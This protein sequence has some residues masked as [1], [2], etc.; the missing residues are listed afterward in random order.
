MINKYLDALA[1]YCDR[2][3]LTS[4][5]KDFY[6]RNSRRFLNFWGPEHHNYTIDDA[7]EYVDHLIFSGTMQA[8]SI[9]ASIR[10]IRILYEKVFHILWDH[11]YIP[12]LVEDKH[13]PNVITLEEFELLLNNVKSLKYKALYALMFSSGLRVSEAV[14]LR[15]DDISRSQRRIHIRKSKS[16]YD[17]YTILSDRCLD[18]LTQY[19]FAFDKPM[20]YLFPSEK[21]GTHIEVNQVQAIL[22][23][24]CIATGFTKPV[25]CHDLRHSFATHLLED[26]VDLHTIQVLLGHQEIVSTE[27]YLTVTNKIFMGIKS[28]FDRE[29]D[30]N[31]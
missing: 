28:P 12:M 6:V 9:N 27:V 10:C 18:I 13:V 11:E 23:K 26:N 2:R 16:R 15:Y 3:N 17:R 29:R 24:A 8:N 30:K 25:H 19:W 14:S 5:T 20:G 21:T 4:N 22:R 31:G 7:R 1:L